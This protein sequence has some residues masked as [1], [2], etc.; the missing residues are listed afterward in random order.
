MRGRRPLVVLLF[1]V[2]SPL[3]VTAVAHADR[4]PTAKQHRQI[5]KAAELPP[6]CAAVR[7]STVSK[8]PKWASVSW[9]PG[10]AKCKPFAANGVEVVKKTKGRW[11]F[12]TAGSSF[13]CGPLY[14]LVPLA[15]VQ[16]LGISCI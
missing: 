6:R 4:A 7:I 1:A 9:K 10:G 13:D 16:D 3:L 12:I 14:K 5:A 8:K 11:R 2:A 15:V